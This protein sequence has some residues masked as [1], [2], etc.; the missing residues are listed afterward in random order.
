MF[1]AWWVT[2]M[3]GWLF[4][5]FVWL[6]CLESEAASPCVPRTTPTVE[7]KQRAQDT[8]MAAIYRFD[9]G[10]CRAAIEEFQAAGELWPAF[11]SEEVVI[12]EGPRKQEYLPFFFAG[13]CL[14][15]EQEYIDA[16]RHL[17]L[18]S[19][20]GHAPRDDK[21]QQVFEQRH[22]DCREWILGLPAKEKERRATEHYKNALQWVRQ[23]Q[24]EQAAQEIWEAIQLQDEDGERVSGLGEGG[25]FPDPYLPR[26]QLGRALAKLP[27]RE[28]A[29]SQFQASIID[30]LDE[31][32]GL[33]VEELRE[34]RNALLL[35]LEG[36]EDAPSCWQWC[37]WSRGR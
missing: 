9:D 1:R 33:D 4:G 37:C 19:C 12:T 15:E 13:H 8:F 17:V 35:G 21:W 32:E 10:Q 30:L 14:Y 24:W 28:E 25:R 36:Q 6:V 5:G 20:R 27:C 2:A 23:K 16:L 18:A 7:E 31:I 29:K 22:Q 34:N 11:E 26:Y 3:T